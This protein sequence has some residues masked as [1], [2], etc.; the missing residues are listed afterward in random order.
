[1]LFRESN[2]EIKHFDCNKNLV[3]KEDSATPKWRAGCMKD[4]D[5]DKPTGL[6]FRWTY[7]LQSGNDVVLHC[8]GQ[9]TYTIHNIPE[10]TL[11]LM[12][13]NVLKSFENFTRVFLE[14]MALENLVVLPP[15]YPVVD[16]QLQALLT[17]L[18][19]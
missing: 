17:E 6:W 16:E 5:T 7:L 18:K 4:N 10:F 12:K 13:L 11:E 15:R 2:M 14:R 19:S 8:V 3:G 9:D 1:M